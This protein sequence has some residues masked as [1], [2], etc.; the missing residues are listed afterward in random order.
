MADQQSNLSPRGSW[1]HFFVTHR[2]LQVHRTD[3]GKSQKTGWLSV[4]PRPRTQPATLP[5]WQEAKSPGI[6]PED[7]GLSRRSRLRCLPRF[8]GIMLS[9]SRV[10]QRLVTELGD[11]GVLFFP[12]G[13]LWSG[14]E[15]PSKGS[16]LASLVPSW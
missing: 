14:N 16:C 11:L 5:T 12:D 13:L 10:L 9:E 1:S 7:V 15:V 6:H 8:S 4:S 3:M 2:C